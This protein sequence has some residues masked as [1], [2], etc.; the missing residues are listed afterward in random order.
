MKTQTNFKSCLTRLRG[1]MLNLGYHSVVTL[2][3]RCRL[4]RTLSIILLLLCIGVG[5]VWGDSYTITFDGSVNESTLVSGTA[6]SI[7]GNST[8]VT[9]DVSNISKAYGPTSDGVKVGSSSNAGN[10]TISL[11]ASGQV[12]PTSIVVYCKLYNSSKAS[13]VNVNNIGAQSVS[14]SWENVTF[15]TSTAL[16]SLTIASSKYI[17][18]KSITIN[19]TPAAFCTTNP[20]VTAG[21]NSSVTSTTATVSCSSGISS[22]GSAG[23]SISSYGFVIGTSA[24]PTVGG[25]GVT[26][27][28]VGATYTTTGTSF[29]KALT[30]LTAST[31]YYVRPYATNGNGTGYGTQT[32]FTTSAPPKYTVTLK[33]DETELEQASAGANVTLPSRTGCTGYTF[34]GWTKSWATAQTEWTTTAPT[35]IPAG[36]Y[37]PTA[38]ENLY[39]VYTKTEGGGTAWSLCSTAASVTAGT[40]V[41]TW[42]NSYYLP[43]ETTTSSNPAVGSG[44]TVSND[45]LSNTV[46]SAMQWTFTGNNTDGYSISHVSGNNTYK[47]SATNAAQGISVTTG[48]TSITWTVSVDNTYGMLLHGSDG[49]SRYLAVYNSGSWRYYATGN[50]YLGTLRLYKQTTASTTSYI[51]VPNCCT[52]LGAINGSV[53][54]TQLGDGITVSDWVYTPTA[55]ETAA[56][57]TDDTNVSSYTVK[58]YKWSGSAWALANANSTTGGA[59]GAQATR[60]GIAKNSKSVTWTGLEY[61]ANYKVTVTAVGDGSTY[62]TD[63]TETAVTTVNSVTL[64]DNKIP[65]NYSI[66]IDEHDNSTYSHNI[67]QA[68]NVSSNTG[69][70]AMTLDAGS[71]YQYKAVFGA[72]T[73]SGT[74]KGLLWYG[75]NGTMTNS[76]CTNWD[77]ASS[78]VSNCGLTTVLG[79]S[80]T[81]SVNFS[82]SAPKVSV[83]YPSANQSA[84]NIVYWDASIV[85]NWDHLYFRVGTSSD[86]NASSDCKVNAQKVPGTDNFY[87]V[88]TAAFT[89]MSAWA[90]TNNCGW[91]G[92]NTNSVYKTNTGDSYSITLSSEYQDYAVDGTGVTLV[93]YGSGAMGSESHD[94]NCRFYTVTK[95]DGMLT[96]TATITTPTNG[97]ITIAYTDVNSSSQSKTATT[98]GLAHRT[99][100]TITATPDSHYELASLTVNGSA[101]TSGD[102]YILDDDATIAATFTLVNYAVTWYAGGTAAGNITTA[103]S[104]STSVAYGSKVTTLPTDPD[105]SPCDKTFV[106]WTNTSSYEHGTSLL[107]TDAAGSPAI[108]AN[109]NFYAV[110][111]TEGTGTSTVFSEDFNTCNGTGGNSGGWSGSIA[112]TDVPN[113]ISSTW[114][115]SNT[116]KAADKCL[117]LGTG[118]S[119]GSAETPGIDCGSATSGTLTFKAGAWDGSSEGTTLSLSASN[120][121][122][123]KSSVTLVKGSFTSYTVAITSIADDITITFYTSSGNQRFFLEDVVVT[124][125]TLTYT[126]HTLTCSDCGTSVTPTFTASPTGGTVAVTKGGSSVTSGSTVKTCSS[127]DLSVTITPASH[128][129]LTDFTATGL[130]DGTATI[131]PTVASTLPKTTAQTFTV[132]VSAGATGTLTLTPTFTED[133]HVNI[134]WMVNGSALTGLGT[135]EGLTFVYSGGDIESLPD[136]PSVPAGCSGTKVFAGWSQNNSGATEEDA[137]YYDD[138]FTVAGPTGITSAQTYYAV[139]AT[140]SADA[141]AGTV[142]WDEPFSGSANDQPTSPTSG[143][144][145]YGSATV[146]YACG[147]SYC[148]LYE[149][150]GAGGTSPELLVPK[151]TRDEVFAV[152]GIPTAG[153]TTLT[154]TY[155]SNQ[156]VSL[157]T[158]TSGVTIG[159]ASID[160]TTYTRTITTNSSSITSFA[161]TFAMTS[162]SNARLD[163]IHLVVPGSGTMTDYL[164]TCAPS[165]TI[166]YNKNTTDAVTN[167]PSATSV[168]QSTGSGTLSSTVPTRATYT[169]DG[170]AETTSGAVAYA[171]GASITGVT[172]DKTL[173]AIWS[174]TA[175][176]E[177]NLNYTTLNKYVGDAAVTLEVTSVSPTGA[178]DGVTWSSSASGVASVTAAGVVSFVAVGTATITATSTVTNTTYA[179]CYVTV[180]TKPTATFVDNIHDGNGTDLDDY[181]LQDVAGTAIVFPT[182]SNTTPGTDDCE[183]QHYVFVGWT[184][185]DNNTDPE[186]HLVTSGTLEDDNDKTFYAVWADGVPGYTYTKLTSNSFSTTA[187]YVIG[188]E[189]N[190]QTYYFYSCTNTDSNN[191]N[192]GCTNAPGT[193]API[194]F[195]LSGTAAALVATSTEATARYLKPLTEKNFQMSASSK[196]ITLNS[197]GTIANPSAEAWTL[198]FNT[199]E[200]YLRWYNSATGTA[201]YFYTVTAGSTVSYRTSCCSNNVAAPTVTATSTAYTVTLT[202]SE[203]E[204]ATGYEIS[205]NGGAWESAT[206]PV[207]KTSLTPGTT[208]TYKVR[209]TYT[210]PQCG[211]LI[212]SGSITTD[213]VYTVTYAGGSGTGSCTTTGSTTDTNSPYEAGVTV[214]LQTNGYTLSGHTFDA[215]VVKDAENNEVTVTNNQFTMPA[216]NVTVTATW[217]AKVDKYYDRMHDGTSAANGGVADES[218]KYYITREGCQYTVPA[219]T[220]DSEGETACHTT[221]YKLLG[222]IASSYLAAD[223]SVSDANKS[224]IFTGGGTKTATGATYYAIWAV[225]S[226]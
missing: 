122:L 112:N 140:S 176:D 156:N 213:D 90:I 69:T 146:T 190:D 34:A 70:I 197:D 136:E 224:H 65:F 110:Y 37:T 160:G 15:S 42:D 219:L 30:S 92:S 85:S 81:F 173:Y 142:L 100:L 199:T 118:S 46:T 79:G 195:S 49:G 57:I 221:H 87:K 167:L 152:T 207:S 98:A 115:L 119:G 32:S 134:T 11:S 80:Y 117:K 143:A 25:S 205:W 97:T 120:C 7:T 166:T 52:P 216:S 211:A 41:I 175:V 48:S 23:C 151:S 178:D 172:G 203:V 74:L 210:S 68:A 186:D 116:T 144:T 88:T 17:W 94:N 194:Q 55:A 105:G 141:L 188:A 113:G 131:S 35:I 130:T 177:I 72:F 153:R 206:S 56:S 185:S 82:G 102:T 45:N 217:T 121:T 107:F 95:T 58:L 91:T 209:G 71:S 109:T 64:V 76:N 84:G 163:D 200:K 27:H 225:I 93:P 208:Y 191:G 214:T 75:Y 106:G 59:S 16:T 47:L 212:A 9:G 108:T 22:L 150:S 43:S 78:G 8:Y 220:D 21:S 158:G 19:Y 39:P 6:A 133:T 114:F 135:V 154:L 226:E 66:Y 54:L 53:N 10:F 159:D 189:Y 170:W 223:G 12:T 83:T 183:S 222:W 61:G 187:K 139:F 138:L 168:L 77:F 182:L 104:P 62:C 103:G 44:I 96:H 181:A 180:R 145:V 3:S 126:G 60:T 2:P 198:R 40:Y 29:S 13:T 20:T 38:N 73:D 132:T 192:G 127:V 165:Y 51:S 123:D 149:E 18:V 111:A 215:W 201:A 129:S 157:T 124:A 155:K 33:D 28:E 174:K 24:N 5:N 137:S 147:A 50:S 36:S 161:L 169:F 162:S 31:T 125:S 86:A 164:T 26:K 202:W 67:I 193:N 128:Y 179:V 204:H 171:A 101:F 99:I 14:S 184:T 148:K 1:L 218:G 63:N 4:H 89:G 196:T